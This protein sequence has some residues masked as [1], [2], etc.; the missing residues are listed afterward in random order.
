E[1][2]QAPAGFF[3][4]QDQGRLI[5]NIQLP[6]STSLERT[7]EV[8]TEV[9]RVAH[10]TPG[11]QNS[12]AFAGM[13]FL[14]RVNSSNFASMFVILKP[15]DER[16]DPQLR[17]TAIM[18]QLRR[19]WAR[20]VPDAQVT[21]FGGSPIPGLGSAGGFKLEIEDRGDLGV[22]ALH[23]QTDALVSKLQQHPGL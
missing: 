3:P 2:R 15:F 4:Q 18:A 7:K 19:E 21:V 20:Q 11:V 1:F 13:S 9:V 5:C 16:P 14:L 8:L 6:D 22:A 12:V 17:D 10:E 23:H